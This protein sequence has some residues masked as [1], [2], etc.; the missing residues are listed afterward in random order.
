M[1]LLLTGAFKYSEEQ[2]GS[3]KLLG[4]EILFIQDERV[5]LQVDVSDIDAVVCN[6]LFLYNDIKKFK[7]LKFIQLTSAG[8][9]R[10]PLDY[11][12]DQGIKLFN[13]KGVYSVPMA[14]WIVL[15]IL[16]IYKKSRMF[17]DAQREHKWEKQRDLLELT[18]KTATIIGFG[19]VGSEVAKRLK[20]FDVK[21]VGVG[22]RKTKSQYID[23][24][25][26]IDQLDKV[27]EKSD[28]IILTLPLTNETSCLIN[29]QK[30]RKMKDNGVLIN[31]SRG[32][33]I[34][35][36]SLI[37]ALNNDKFLGVA[38]DVFIEEPLRA[39]NQLWKF[40]RVIV[41]PHN[42]FVSD[43]VGERIFRLILKNLG[44]YS[45]LNS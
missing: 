14:E 38:L 25:Y 31:V 36:F 24:F 37:E 10:V 42:S 11:I 33:I 43:R 21:V 9:D 29:T 12:K 32:G 40:D 34:D 19:D 7:N 22:R 18:S 15:K 17:Y 20:A 44:D 16:E 45:E 30:I 2:L 13:A 35:E 27:L 8:L 23:E 41:T 3:L 4:Y 5:P 39:E 28:I 1:K 6:G 26:L